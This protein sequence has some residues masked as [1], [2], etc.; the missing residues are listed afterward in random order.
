MDS[1]L[2]N[3]AAAAQFM[4]QSVAKAFGARIVK[5]VQELSAMRV[6]DTI[7]RM[8][9]VAAVTAAALI[10]T[11]LVPPVRSAS[12]VSMARVVNNNACVV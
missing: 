10:H 6:R 8:V 1:F 3:G 12:P 4:F 5:A 2:V 9:R 11:L 7:V